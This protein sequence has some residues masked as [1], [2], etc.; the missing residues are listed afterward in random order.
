MRQS[1]RKRGFKFFHV[2]YSKFQ[3]VRVRVR[4]RGFKICDVR[5]RVRVR[6]FKIF[7][8][9]VH[10][11]VRGQ[12]RTRMSADTSVRV[13]RSLITILEYF[14]DDLEMKRNLGFYL[15]RILI[16]SIQWSICI[17]HLHSPHDHSR[18]QVFFSGHCSLAPPL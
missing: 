18:M 17:F 3:D 5:V 15:G 13:H 12:E 11:R 1:E 16:H 10:V 14:H 7:H 2:R 4:V 9:R 8:V 6:G